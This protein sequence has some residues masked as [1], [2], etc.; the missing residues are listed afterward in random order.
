MQIIKTVISWIAPILIG[1][2]F[3]GIIRFFLYVPVT[4]SGDSMMPNLQDRQK[5]FAWLPAV[6]KRGSVVAFDAREEDP[7]IG[8]GQKYYIKRVI[9]IAGDTVESKNG[10]IY[11]NGKK[12]NQSYLSEAARTSGT[13]NWNLSTLSSPDSVWK[14]SDSHWNDGKATVV[15]KDSYFVLGD[16]RA[17][18][19]D[20]RYFGFVAKKHIL[21]VTFVYPW[22]SNKSVINSETDK[23]F[24]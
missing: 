17:E 18:S 11:V 3:A 1:L 10:N 21:G 13:G 12:I 8:K 2:A 14:T 24:N 22:E 23:F 20:S 6:V 15:P 5:V 7:G 16:N 19:E 9:G 4:V